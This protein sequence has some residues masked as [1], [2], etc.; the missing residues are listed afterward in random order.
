MSFNI[1]KIIHYCWFGEGEKSEMI[2][3]C[4]KSWY[5]NLPDYE[6][7]EWNEENFPVSEYR[8]AEEAL[9]KKKFAFVS[10]VARLY[11]LRELGG[12]YLDTDVEV[13]KT[14]DDLLHNVAFLGF[15]R[16]GNLAS[17]TIGSEREGRF[18]R[19]MLQYYK[20]KPFILKDQKMELQPNTVIITNF[21]REKGLKLINEYQDIKGY[22]TVYPKQY[23]SPELVGG[24]SLNMKETYCIHYFKGSWVR[25]SARAKTKLVRLLKYFLVIFFGINFFN[26]IKNAIIHK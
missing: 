19:D 5:K 4:I 22:A 13:L 2:K 18:V 16:I 15:E 26:K 25:S 8:F 10:D 12:I 1:P 24:K 14:F 21:L 11:A 17:S 3:K 7:I 9:R 20:D 6:I 23:F